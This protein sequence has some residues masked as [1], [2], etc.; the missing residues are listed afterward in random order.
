[1]YFPIT[2]I[3]TPH[4]DYQ[5]S[6]IIRVPVVSGFLDYLVS[7]LSG[8]LDYQGS[9]GVWIIRVPGLSGVWA[10]RVPG[11]SGLWCLDYQGSRIIWCLGYQGSWIIR[12][13]VVSGPSGF[14]CRST[15]PIVGYCVYITSRVFP[16]WW[17][18]CV[19]DCLPSRYLLLESRDLTLHMTL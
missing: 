13:P 3:R 11:L 5:G 8:F 17:N 2:E 16:T 14:H 10:I 9:S 6:W 18:P 19:N 4:T 1:M 15:M 12:V 7:G